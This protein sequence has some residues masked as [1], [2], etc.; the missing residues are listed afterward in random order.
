MQILFY[1]TKNT[2]G[3]KRV[4]SGLDLSRMS[5]TSEDIQYRHQHLPAINNS[6]CKRMVQIS[7]ICLAISCMQGVSQ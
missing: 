6:M 4:H 3:W 7:T 1:L 2:M 5:I